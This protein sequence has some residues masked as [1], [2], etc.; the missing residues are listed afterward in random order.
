MTQHWMVILG[1]LILLAAIYAS[2]GLW[3]SVAR[4]GTVGMTLANHGGES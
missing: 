3:G 1:P 4:T 2:R